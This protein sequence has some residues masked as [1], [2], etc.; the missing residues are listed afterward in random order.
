MS[1][2]LSITN[3]IFNRKV[4]L[5]FYFRGLS[6]FLLK[7]KEDIHLFDLPGV[8]V[9]T[10]IARVIDYIKD[11]NISEAEILLPNFDEPLIDL[12]FGY[13]AQYLNENDASIGLL[14]EDES[15]IHIYQKLIEKYGITYSE[16]R[17]IFNQKM[18]RNISHGLPHDLDKTYGVN[19]AP[20]LPQED[21]VLEV[22]GPSSPVSKAKKTPR[23]K[24]KKEIEDKTGLEMDK[25]FVDIL[26]DY[27]NES[28]KNNVD[29]YT[30]GG[31]TRQVFS[32][33]LCNRDSVPRK[34]T[35]ICLIIGLELPFEKAKLLIASAG[36]ALSRSIVFD[37]V[38]SKYL[39]K[40]IFDLDTINDELESR[41]C[42]LLGWKPRED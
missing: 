11:N 7:D 19:K 30:K 34:D 22:C 17:G 23:V 37:S 14:V 29:V 24:K 32:K 31:I 12:T 26:I 18:K 4:H 20:E 13:I 35:V 25:P 6:V 38:V 41:Q 15:F 39:R 2:Y 10:P 42:A 3:S 33:I 8:M 1:Y 40:G 9:E 16:N 28:G 27:L 21:G 36:Y 5:V